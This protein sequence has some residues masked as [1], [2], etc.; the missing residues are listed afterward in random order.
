[1]LTLR[2]Y[3][4]FLS[5]LASESGVIVRPVQRTLTASIGDSITL[6]MNAPSGSY[7]WTHQGVDT[8]RQWMDGPNI[9][10]GNVTKADAGIYSCSL[11]DQQSGK[12]HG[13]TR[14]IVRGNYVL[15]NS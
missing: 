2:V 4:F 10:L 6:Q 15:S 8:D 12:L 13:I 5:A 11:S 1:M 3:P 9:E 14:L 7:A